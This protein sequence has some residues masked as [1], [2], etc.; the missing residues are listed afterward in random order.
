MSTNPVACSSVPCR[1]SV[2]ETCGRENVP[3][4]RGIQIKVKTL[5]RDLRVKHQP[6]M[7]IYHD[8]SYSKNHL[9]N[10]KPTIIAVYFH[11]LIII[12]PTLSVRSS[13]TCCFKLPCE[14]YLVA[15]RVFMVWGIFKGYARAFGSTL[16][17]FSNFTGNC[18]IYLQLLL[19]II[20]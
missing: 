20:V 17:Y 18:G 11:I 8:N 19:L 16:I 12:L 6:P 2:P 3:F 5:R 15:F 14:V 7:L 13:Y 4:L 1:Q 10:L 9:S